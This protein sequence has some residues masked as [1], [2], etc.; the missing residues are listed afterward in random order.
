MSTIFGG[1]GSDTIA[2]PISTAL[3]DIIF[4]MQ[5]ADSI[6]GA[7]AGDVLVGGAAADTLLGGAGDDTLDGQEARLYG[8][9]D[10]RDVLFGGEDN[11]RIFV[12]ARDR[13]V[14]G[15]GDDLI[16]QLVS[17]P[18]LT[19]APGGQTGL[20][21]YLFRSITGPVAI[22][23]GAGVDTLNLH[24]ADIRGWTITGVERLHAVSITLTAAQLNAFA[25]IDAINPFTIFGLSGELELYETGKVTLDFGT[26]PALLDFR[27]RIGARVEELTV[28]NR[29]GAQTVVVDPTWQGSLVFD[30]FSNSGVELG[31][32][33][34]S[35][36]AGGDSLYGD[37]GRDTL[38]GHDGNDL[39]WGGGAATDTL[40]PIQD[41]DLLDGGEGND[42]LSLFGALDT[43]LGGAGDD[44]FHGPA[45]PADPFRLPALMD[46]GTG[47][48]T[49]RIFFRADIT[50]LNMRSVERLEGGSVTLTAAQLNGFERVG[51]FRQGEAL[52]LELATAG[53]IDL[54][55][56]LD[57]TTGAVF[58]R[59]LGG[60]DTIL[61]DPAYAGQ[62]SFSTEGVSTRG[63]VIRAARGND[64]IWTG[65]GADTVLGGAGGD[66]MR[67]DSGADSLRGE[68]GNDRL[69]GDENFGLPG[70][71]TL[72]GG[73]GIDTL[74]GGFGDDLYIVDSRFDLVEEA[75]GAGR[76]RV[77]SSVGLTLFANVE[78][79]VLTGTAATLT[80]NGDDNR[81][82]GNAAANRLNGGAGNDTL[83]GEGGADTLDGGLNADSMAGG[84]GDDLYIVNAAT[85][86]ILELPGGGRDRVQANVSF[87][88]GAEIEDLTLA[89]TIGLAG[90]GNALANVI[91]GNAGANRLTGA[92]G[93]DTLLG[94]EGADT[95]D[96]GHGADSLVGGP[97]ADR[98]RFAAPGLGADTIDGF[99]SGVDAILFSA[100]GFGGLLP[101]GAL[102]AGSF[103][104][105][106]A[107][108][109]TAPQMVFDSATGIL[110]W[111]ADG[112]GAGAAVPL[113]RLLDGAAMAPTD[114]VVVA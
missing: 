39:L 97:W 101:P 36:G 53:L 104:G 61:M 54:T 67:G 90:L 111:D 12:S 91:T 105:T 110:A 65:Q 95:L 94:G 48:D 103:S 52:S 108:A 98:F 34:V 21:G 14:A 55:G 3:A 73:P 88:L 45:S 38:R 107:P 50:G 84:A 102:P 86:R 64:E 30:P 13:V 40:P 62:F 51:G 70:N 43:V 82:T 2:P 41:A 58:F 78:E 27:G 23:G 69:R 6:L 49:L 75:P 59:A 35:G 11:D 8:A 26:G 56:R 77:L 92:G 113:A 79:A 15:N 46:G 63:D 37:G 76:D 9:D 10:M 42:T 17:V 24:G 71:D 89:G 18:S 57:L 1:V 100:A 7:G 47:I 19:I 93:N 32:D 22:D 87:I 114:I 5:G 4:G 31:N 33:S 20:S 106:G 44:A 112:T 25:T 85:D 109:G 99:E 66:T 16:D 72:D 74:I 83:L 81:L 29:A 80:G 96:G 28:L 68:A 60:G